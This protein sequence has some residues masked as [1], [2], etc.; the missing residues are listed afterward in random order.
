MMV[1]DN[2]LLATGYAGAPRGL[3]HCDEVGH[4]IHVVIKPDGTKSEHCL[5]TAHAEQN[6]I[7]QA[8][9]VGVSLEGA[10]CFV[11]MEPCYACAKMIINAGIDRVIC[12]KKYHAAQKTREAFKL[13]GIELIVL[14]DEVEAY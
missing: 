13:A 2:H 4:D 9:K 3:P 12:R 11:N 6:A 14:E 5:R 10:I 7:T 1:R 8:A